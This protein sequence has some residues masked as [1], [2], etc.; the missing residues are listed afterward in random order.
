VIGPLI[1]MRAIVKVEA[2]I[3]DAVKKGAKI[4]AGRQA[5]CFGWRLF[6]ADRV[7]R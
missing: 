2:H 1:E 5:A 7:R 6:R 4:L 3:A